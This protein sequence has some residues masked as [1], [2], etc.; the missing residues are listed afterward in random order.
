MCESDTSEFASKALNMFFEA[1]HNDAFLQVVHQGRHHQWVKPKKQSTIIIK[2]MNNDQLGRD[3]AS[4]AAVD[5]VQV[6]DPPTRARSLP[7]SALRA[8]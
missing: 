6:C 2:Q 7:P 8:T 3:P 5:P 1:V 4:E